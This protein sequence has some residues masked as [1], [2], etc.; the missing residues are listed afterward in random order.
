MGFRFVQKRHTLRFQSGEEKAASDQLLTEKSSYSS[1]GTECSAD[2]HV[3]YVSYFSYIIVIFQLDYCN[4]MRTTLEKYPY[5][6][7]G[8]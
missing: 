2:G 8:L 3:I 1:P 5:P 7:A 4:Y 6:S